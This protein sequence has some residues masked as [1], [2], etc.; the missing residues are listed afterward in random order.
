MA[1]L[2]QFHPTFFVKLPSKCTS[3]SPNL[4][5]SRKLL[6][7]L[8]HIEGWCST[9]GDPLFCTLSCLCFP[10]RRKVFLVCKQ[11]IIKQ[12]GGVTIQ[13]SFLPHPCLSSG[14]GFHLFAGVCH[15]KT[16]QASIIPL[17][18]NLADLRCS[19]LLAGVFYAQH[20]LKMILWFF[21]TLK[22]TSIAKIRRYLAERLLNAKGRLTR[23]LAS[24]LGC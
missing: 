18:P 15:W 14:G 22:I 16:L 1:P 7:L 23:Y 10:I 9:F 6:L 4:F 2:F 12:Q 24:G 8:C 20:Q 17:D 21:Q 5:S 13:S 19:L 11:Q 3:E